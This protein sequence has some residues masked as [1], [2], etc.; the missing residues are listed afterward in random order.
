MRATML[1]SLSLA[2]VAVAAQSVPALA[3]N[4]QNYECQGGAHFELALMPD[5]KS[6]YVQLDGKSLRLPRVASVTGTRFRKGDVTIWIKGERATLRR[7]GKRIECK[8]K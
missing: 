8:I 1:M 7:A 6:S 5:T 4:F 3:Q 2:I